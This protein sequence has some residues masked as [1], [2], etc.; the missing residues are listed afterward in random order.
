[1]YI[2][3]YKF[4]YTCN[5]H[6]DT[7][8]HKIDSYKTSNLYVH[9]MYVYIYIY[10][11]T[12][13]WIQIYITWTSN[14]LNGPKKV[15]FALTVNLRSST[16]ATYCYSIPHLFPNFLPF[17]T[18]AYSPKNR[19]AT[20]VKKDRWRSVDRCLCLYQSL[21]EILQTID[22]LDLAIQVWHPN[23]LTETAELEGTLWNEKRSSE[24]LP[25]SK[26]NHEK[27]ATNCGMKQLILFCVH[28][29][30][31]DSVA[32]IPS[33]WAKASKALRATWRSPW[34]LDTEQ[35]ASQCNIA[36]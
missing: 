11:Y 4:K 16:I 18:N 32:S 28:T 17:K 14:D 30:S 34:I 22:S 7:R 31:R 5:I 15:P 9:I 25:L 35:I 1:M 20:S 36:N 12:C 24:L 2:Y 26:K 10:K 33:R 6:N 21:S 8:T 23:H 29:T 13:W 3:I 27:I 19:Y